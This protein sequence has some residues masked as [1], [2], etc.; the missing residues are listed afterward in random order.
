MTTSSLWDAVVGQELVVRL[1]QA[2]VTRPVHAY[3]FVGRPGV[4]QID[5]SRAFA[6][7][8][9][10]AASP[11]ADATE[12]RRRVAIDVH[13]DVVNVERVGAFIT[14]E[15]ASEITRLSMASPTEG[16]RKVIVVHDMHLVRDAGA[17]LLKTIEEPPP[18]CVFVLLADAMSP[19]LSTIASRCV[20][21]E[22]TALSDDTI[23]STPV[24]E[25]IDGDRA[26]AAVGMAGGRLD[27][28]RVLATDTGFGD[29]I[30]LWQAAPRR[31]DGAGATVA[32]VV[33]ELLEAVDASALPLKAVHE[34]ELKELS[35]RE[36][37]TGTRGSGR[38]QLVQR[39]KRE[40]RRYRTDELRAGLSA[41]A[42]EYRDRLF[43]DPNGRETEQTMAALD[44]LA[45]AG[46]ALTFNGN[47][48]LTLQVLMGKLDS[49]YSS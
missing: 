28:A 40:A 3:L 8:L 41:L 16:P 38:T 24:A 2:A 46:Q 20:P 9:L 15:Q 33:D 47:E 12:I 21:V 42:G 4:G 18:S 13:P 31:L 23:V 5:A 22:F 7:D 17:A 45:T 39:H 36:K 48:R 34:R 30:R 10:C 32:E 19:E 25:G 27:R 35:E 6:A 11:E 43:A 29:R 37:V 26:S 1:L 49:V 14:V 44:A